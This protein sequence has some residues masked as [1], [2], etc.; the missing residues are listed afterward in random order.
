VRVPALF[1]SSKTRKLYAP[2]KANRQNVIIDPLTGATVRTA[3]SGLTPPDHLA[4]GET[5]DV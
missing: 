3:C 5:S 2:A 4:V 1:D